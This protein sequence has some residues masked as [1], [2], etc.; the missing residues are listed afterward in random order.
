MG[1]YDG[2]T[3][4][5]TGGGSGIGEA[6][7][8]LLVREGA[9]VVVADWDAGAAAAVAARTGSTAVTFD[10]SSPSDWRALVDAHAFTVAVINAG[11]GGRFSDLDAVAD[12]EIDRILGVNLNGVLYGTRELARTMAPRGGGRISVTASLGGLT[13]HHMSPVYAA[14]KWG[15]VGWVRAIAPSLVQ[16]GVRVNG[17]CPGLVDTP[18]LGPGGG[19]MMRQ[20]GLKTLTSDEV[21]AAHDRA[22]STEGTGQLFTVQVGREVE[23]F[24]FAAVPGYQG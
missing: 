3:A 22:L 11:V 20:M 4:L 8:E 7:V 10:Q 21:A 15:V 14:S 17:I 9:Q 18:I 13:A 6:T 19:E 5:V 1:R 12:E 23:P 24:E 2:E 16:R